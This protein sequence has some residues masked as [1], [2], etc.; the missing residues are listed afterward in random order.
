MGCETC[1]MLL[2]GRVAA[3]HE[4]KCHTLQLGTFNCAEFEQTV[5]TI[6]SQIQYRLTQGSLEGFNISRCCSDIMMGTTPNNTALIT[7]IFTYMASIY[8]HLVVN[9]F[10]DLELLDTT[11]SAAM[12]L[13]STKTPVHLLPTLVSP[14]FI[15][16]SVARM[17]DEHFFRTIFSSPPLQNPLLKHRQKI[18][19]ALE[20]IWSRRQTTLVFTWENSVELTHDILLL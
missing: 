7:Q 2:I 15:I 19:P 1:V 12:T 5:L 17:E 13:L 9:G 18:L 11:V 20:E 6:N 16:G 8:M 10:Q 3:L 4:H 14:L